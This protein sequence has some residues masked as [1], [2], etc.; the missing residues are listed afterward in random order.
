MLGKDIGYI[1]WGVT[2]GFQKGILCSS[3]V[4]GTEELK[5]FP[6]DKMRQIC[7]ETRGI[8]Y[9]YGINITNNYSFVSV[10]N[11][12]LRDRVG[13]GAY[14]SI[15]LFTKKSSSFSVNVVSKLHSLMDFYVSKQGESLNLNFTKEQF[16]EQLKNISSEKDYSGISPVSEKQGLYVYRSEIEIE[17]YFKSPKI[18]GFNEVLFFNDTKPDLLEKLTRYEKV[19]EFRKYTQVKLRGYDSSRYTL[20]LDGQLLNPTNTVEYGCS[21]LPNQTIK[22]V[23]SKTK[24]TQTFFVGNSNTEKNLSQLFYVENKKPKNNDKVK[25]VLVAVVFLI[26]GSI[27]AYRFSS[28]ENNQETQITQTT[29]NDTAD[30]KNADDSTSRVDETN[31]NTAAPA[32]LK[33]TFSTMELLD[34]GCYVSDPINYKK[35]PIIKKENNKWLHGKSEN[36]L[37]ECASND[38]KNLFDKFSASFYY[39]V[40]ENKLR[41]SKDTTLNLAKWQTIE[42]K[43]QES[44]FMFFVNKG[45]LDDIKT[46]ESVKTEASKKEESAKKEGA[47]KKTETPPK[48]KDTDKE[49]KTYND[50][51]FHLKEELKACENTNCKTEV[52][53]K[54]SALKT[55]Y[56]E[57]SK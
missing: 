13:R 33:Q 12:N 8:G 9:F 50:Q 1:I 45:F 38:A 42:K 10:F 24:T 16:E 30:V 32:R 55:K 21:A 41:A 6:N 19:K 57:C 29:E 49:C 2:D 26:I 43:D 53:Q 34:E 52:N 47:D 37:T 54:I 51:L 36:A 27:A 17:Q 5:S 18:E 4:P 15:T 14:I 40:V 35:N 22:V 56:K 48:K 20:Y 28:R 3:E 11:G 46:V 44:I 23:D 7:N 25:M 31:S 39:K